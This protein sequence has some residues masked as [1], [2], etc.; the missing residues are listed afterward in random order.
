VDGRG[1][2]P[3]DTSLFDGRGEGKAA[4][5]HEGAWELR[6]VGLVPLVV[7]LCRTAGTMDGPKGG[8]GEDDDPL[9]LLRSHGESSTGKG[10]ERKGH[11]MEEIFFCTGRRAFWGLFPRGPGC[12]R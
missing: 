8:K 9:L 5:P 6:R 1:E 10:E 2:Q 4:G 3:M 7:L 11:G 12:R